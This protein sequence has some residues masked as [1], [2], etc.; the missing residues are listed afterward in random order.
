MIGH[1]CHFDR[2]AADLPARGERDVQQFGGFNGVVKKEF[3][4]IA[5]AVEHEFVGVLGFD[6]EVL[7]HHR[8]EGF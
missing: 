4:K 7:L 3:V 2:L 8:G 5:H 6:V 1:A